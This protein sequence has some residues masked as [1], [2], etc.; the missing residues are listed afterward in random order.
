MKPLI[1]QKLNNILNIK[2]SKRMS[3]IDSIVLQQRGYTKK[4][5]SDR[6]ESFQIL[7]CSLL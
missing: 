4:T 6:F 7:Q 2:K 1:F 5:K 3:D